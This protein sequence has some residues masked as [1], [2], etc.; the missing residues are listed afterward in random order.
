MRTLILMVL[1]LLALSAPAPAA[2]QTGEERE[3]LAVVQRMF[4]A[5]RTRDTV[6]LRSVFGPGARL[7]GMRTARD[8]SVRVQELTAEQFVRF[9][10]DD[11]RAEWI[12]RMWEPEVRIT[13]TLATVWTAYDFHFATQFSH[14]GHDAFQLLKLP[15]GWK[16]VSIADTYVREGCPRRDPPG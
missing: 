11:Q 1:A 14:C 5:M 15:E 2:A 8:G 12:E 7:V 3:V 6:A 10:A 9:V 4:H 13:G 16:I